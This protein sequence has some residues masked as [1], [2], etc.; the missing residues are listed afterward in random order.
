MSFKKFA[1]DFGGKEIILNY[2]NRRWGFT[3]T[4][5]VGEVMSLIRKRQPRTLQEWEDW[6]FQNV[7]TNTKS[8]I[9]I[10]K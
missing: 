3:K 8:P 10:S 6:Y 2:A 4:A 9:K 7:Y 1:K 5:K